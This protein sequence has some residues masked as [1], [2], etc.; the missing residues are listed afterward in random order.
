MKLLSQKGSHSILDC[1]SG[2]GAFTAIAMNAGLHVTAADLFTE[3]FKVADMHCTHVD[4]NE[5]LPFA[6]HT[7]DAVT[8]LN[9]LHRVWARGRCISEFSRV[10]K[11]GGVLLIS[12]P[13]ST[14][15]RRLLFLMT[16]TIT[17]TTVGP[18][19]AFLVDEMPSLSFRTNLSI[20]N[21]TSIAAACRMKVTALA[22]VK[23]CLMSTM[24]APLALV[25]I[26]ASM[27]SVFG[28]FP[29][30]GA[31]NANRLPGLFCMNIVLAFQR[32]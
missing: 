20:V 25:P 19:A 24:L 4:L 18:P 22:G 21:V 28:A 1:P 9:G 8:C 23:P 5:A 31:Q 14:L 16:G 6:D 10:L 7:F 2:E 12:F 32:E 15:F 29:G 13:N 17:K 26:L 11:P 3:Q 27:A 30:M